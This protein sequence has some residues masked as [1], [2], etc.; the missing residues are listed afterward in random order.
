MR[1][2]N[3]SSK[4]VKKHFQPV[5]QLMSDR[6]TVVNVWGKR[7]KLPWLTHE[8]FLTIYHFCK[9]FFWYLQNWTST[10]LWCV[11]L[12][13]MSSTTHQRFVEVLFGRYQKNILPEWYMVKNLSCVSHGSLKRFPHT[14]TT[15]GHIHWVSSMPFASINPTNLRTNMWKFREKILRIVDFEKHI[16]FWVGHFEFFFFFKKKQK[17]L[18]MKISPNLY[19]RMDG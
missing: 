8:R 1:L 2:S 9:I 19:G 12:Y 14:F 5:L 11:V 15:H 13:V 10:D 6:L 7:F 17:N 18:S 3:I 16:L 4:T